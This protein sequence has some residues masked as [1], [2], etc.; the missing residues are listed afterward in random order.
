MAGLLL[1]IMALAAAAGTLVTFR[2]GPLVVG[3]IIVLILGIWATA[4]C[5][6]GFPLAILILAGIDAVPGPTLENIRAVQALTAQDV[7]VILLILFL[8]TLNLLEARP[9]ATTGR[10]RRAVWIWA[11]CFLGVFLVI[12]VRTTFTDPVSLEHAALFGRDFAYFAL[13]LPLL[14]S[15]LRDQRLRRCMLLTLAVGALVSGV[16]QILA[17]AGAADISFLVHSTKTLDSQTGLLRIYTSAAVVPVAGLP[18]GVGFVLFD[19]SHRARVLGAVLAL[20]SGAAVILSLTRALYVG[21]VLGLVVAGI[22]WM[23]AGD[24]LSLQGARRVLSM[25]AAVAV[26]VVL[27]VTLH[28]PAEVSNALSGVSGR[29]NSIFST[30]EHQQQATNTLGYRGIEIRELEYVLGGKWLFGL[31]FLDTSDVYNPYVPN[32]SIRNSDTGYLNIVMTMG[33]LGTIVYYLPILGIPLLLAA[34]RLSP[35]R[36]TLDS[37]LAFG[38]LAWAVAI[39]VSSKTLAIL[40]SPTGVVSAA[41]LFALGVA[42]FDDS[43]HEIAMLRR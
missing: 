40:F 4:C 30:L 1:A 27:L 25:A 33:V 9:R 36:G 8:A 5:G 14:S 31:G 43:T 28:P 38:I 41:V 34:R 10:N 23:A 15:P 32:G 21:E 29:A 13:L 22:V 24:K 16:A 37:P 11:L 20:V 7:A 6:V 35:R 42:V 2:S 12:A 19:S 17:S 18:I 26:A 39:I 3:L